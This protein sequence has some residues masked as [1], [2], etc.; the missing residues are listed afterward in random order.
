M[1]IVGTNGNDNGV[2]RPRLNGTGENDLI[3]GLLGNDVLNGAGGADVLRAE[4]GSD[5]LNGGAGRDSLRGGGDNDTLDGGNDTVQDDLDGGSGIDSYIV[6]GGDTRT[7]IEGQLV[8]N[9]QVD[10]I[11]EIVFGGT[12]TV[13]IIGIRR[14][15]LDENV[16]NAELSP[17]KW[18]SSS[19]SRDIVGNSSNNSIKGNFINNFIA[20]GDGDDLLEGG[21][22]DDTVR[23]DRGN[24]TLI[25]V[26]L[27][28]PQPGQGEKDRL[29][30][31]EDADKFAIATSTQDFYTS[32]S[33]NDYALITDFVKGA[34]KIQIKGS[35]TR[36]K[37][38]TAT[39]SGVGSSAADTRILLR[40]TNEL[41]AIAQDVTALGTPDFIFL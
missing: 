12:D 15:V 22:G 3:E 28:S 14:Y 8:P 24:D 38:E 7:D 11:N 32:S 2:Q 31:G 40:D 37:L 35:F 13:E 26:S 5:Y 20:G 6:R 19:V 18:Y 9:I 4:A 36:Y 27:S 16:E 1:N 41:V 17:I 39:V 21:K 29:T 33:L 34:D 23:G 25:G 10:V 30:G